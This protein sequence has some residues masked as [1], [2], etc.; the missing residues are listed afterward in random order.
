MMDNQ[1]RIFGSKSPIP[2][3]QAIS[4]IKRCKAYYEEN[5]NDISGFLDGYDER[6]ET[7]RKYG[8]D[9]RVTFYFDSRLDTPEGE[10]L[11]SKAEL[12]KLY[13]Q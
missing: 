6:L 9:V 7:L 5:G 11:L 3:H 12:D 13:G 10:S 8:N 4:E 1:K 2:A